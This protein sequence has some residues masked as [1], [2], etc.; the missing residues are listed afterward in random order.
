MHHRAALGFSAGLMGAA[1]LGA[2]SPMDRLLTPTPVVFT[3][4]QDRAPVN[5]A[6][7]I[8]AS[9]D[10]NL[11]Y[12]TDRAP[13]T[14]PQTN[15]LSYG[16]ER[17]HTMSFGSIDIRIEPD[18]SG[19]MGEVKVGGIKEIGRFPEVPYPAVVTSSGYRRAPDVVAAHEEAVASLQG[20]IRR[21]LAKTERKEV[22]VFTHGYNNT[23]ND[24]ADAMGTICRLL[25]RDFVC[26][27][28]TW[29]AGGSRGAFLGYNV[30]IESGE[31]A[32]ADMRKAIRAIGETEGVR[33]VDF[34]AHSRGTDVLASAFQQLGREGYVSRKSVTESLRVRNIVLFAPDIDI[35]VASTKIFDVFSDPDVP[36]GAKKNPS[37]TIFKQGS[38]HITMYSNP[39]DQALGLSSSI[40]GSRLRLGQLD[41]SGWQAK[42]LRADPGH[43]VDLIEVEEN[44]GAFGH[45]YFL[46][47]PA[48]GSDLVALIRYGL[49]P[50]DPGRPLVQISKAFWRIPEAQVVA[51]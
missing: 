16:S 32:V 50:G 5:G 24:A 3:A 28:L 38:F 35:D 20:E 42:A 6:R 4:P 49:K 31:F 2:C 19:A 51:R 15:A 17:S 40:F 12:V 22:V 8:S 14:D 45:G 44:T 47:N 21:R 48:V 13:I 41:L 10:L 39:A 23:F 46:S 25:G 9:D 27:L 37:A 1:L 29:P 36:Y 26:V 30:D 18:S 33:G 34:I 7:P 11:L 43:L